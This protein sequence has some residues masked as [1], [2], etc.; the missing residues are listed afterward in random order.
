L[1]EEEAKKQQGNQP[2]KMRKSNTVQMSKR[3]LST[4]EIWKELWKLFLTELL[5]SEHLEREI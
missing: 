1:K 5:D 3:E 2:T 4:D